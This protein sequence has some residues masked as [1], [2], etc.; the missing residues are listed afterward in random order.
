MDSITLAHETQV[1]GETFFQGLNKIT[2]NP[3]G[4][5]GYATVT[6]L[7]I[8]ATALENAPSTE[9]QILEKRVATQQH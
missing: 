4:Q 8:I 7:G 3:P 2:Q 9:R 6:L 1:S 5:A